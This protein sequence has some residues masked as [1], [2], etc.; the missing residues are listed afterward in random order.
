MSASSIELTYLHQT[1]VFDARH[2]VSITT[3]GRNLC[4][5]SLT[6][7]VSDRTR[8]SWLVANVQIEDRVSSVCLV[9]LVVANLEVM[10]FVFPT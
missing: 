6:M 1:S 9:D 8:Y 7:R 4:S 2:V 5:I 10:A 3:G